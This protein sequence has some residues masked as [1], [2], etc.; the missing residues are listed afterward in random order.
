MRVRLTATVAVVSALF[1]GLAAYLVSERTS[2]QV[3][4]GVAE[5]YAIAIE[6][7]PAPSD[8]VFAA[9]ETYR[10]LTDAG[11]LDE[12][13]ALLGR[14]ITPDR[15]S[16]RIV[17]ADAG[18]LGIGE[19][20]ADNSLV[21]AA[22]IVTSIGD[23]LLAGVPA[24]DILVITDTPTEGVVVVEPSEIVVAP[25][26]DDTGVMQ[27]A[28]AVPVVNVLE[29]VSDIGRELWIGA[30]LLTI[31][32]TMATWYLTGRALRPVEDITRRVD[33][34]TAAGAG[35]RV[36]EPPQN[37][38]IGHLARTVN[39]MLGRLDHAAEAQRRF[40]ADASHELRS[41]LAVI[42]AEA[43]VALAHPDSDDW[44]RGAAAVVEETDRLESLVTDLLTLAQHDE[45]GS[46]P[47]G[48]MA[49]L[50]HV[51]T[52][53]AARARRVPIDTL[54]VAPAQVRGAPG[55]LTRIVRHLL[56]NAARHATDAVR[57]S[58][59]SDGAEA[60]LMVDDDGQGVPEAERTRVFERFARLEDERGR[61]SGGAGLGLAVV[62]AT[63]GTLGG[64]VAVE[65]SDLGGARFTVRL[66]MAPA[67][68]TG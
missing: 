30:G 31:L 3:L 37:D 9:E 24:T 64:T 17:P 65:R 45:G 44:R 35:G 57:V 43:E 47:P 67:S 66:P 56:D 1:L 21:L 7:A 53:E 39:A 28:T 23:P 55:E 22:G 59:R 2:S 32:A 15:S 13:W 42:R 4:D 29:S 20:D 25:G 40:V 5:D 10:S 26:F 63:V 46:A 68:A 51:V 12:F 38:E 52:A 62:A 16:V 60:V 19:R 49:D 27:A 6:D 14:T 48:G 58:V 61:D 54:A 18:D 34:I 50:D 11:L 8:M 41:P 36:P 33:A